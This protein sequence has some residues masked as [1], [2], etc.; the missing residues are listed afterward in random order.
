LGNVAAAPARRRAELSPLADP[1]RSR[2][3]GQP[4]PTCSAGWARS[5]ACS[6]AAT[7]RARRW[8]GKAARG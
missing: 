5:R 4:T 1:H 8:A 2:D 3:P 7:W 6:R